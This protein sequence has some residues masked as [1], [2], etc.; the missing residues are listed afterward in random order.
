MRPKDGERPAS[1][2][3]ACAS[4][5]QRKPHAV[6]FEV[7]AARGTLWHPPNRG[8]RCPQAIRRHVQAA[9]P[10][11]ATPDAVATLQWHPRITFPTA[12]VRAGGTLSP[13]SRT[14]IVATYFDATLRMSACDMRL[15]W[16]VII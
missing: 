8:E 10:T 1:L 5:L 11:S 7:V 16:Q 12:L 15:P 2:C 14:P 3:E 4:R 6:D 9:V 13:A